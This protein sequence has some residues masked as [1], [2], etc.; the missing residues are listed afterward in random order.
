MATPGSTGRGLARQHRLADDGSL[1]VPTLT[2]SSILDRAELPEV[3]LIKLDIEGGE[4]S[5]LESLPAWGHRVRC[6]VAEL[7]EVDALLDYDWFSSVTRAAGFTPMPAGTLF[8]GQPG[9]VRNDILG[10]FGITSP[11]SY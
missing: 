11:P 1:E 6:I 10:S 3:D 2:I 5:V 7:H 4:K 8:L 9:A